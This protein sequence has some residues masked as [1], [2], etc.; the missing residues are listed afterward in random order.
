MAATFFKK[1]LV[2]PAPGSYM[3]V[4]RFYNLFNDIDCSIVSID[5]SGSVITFNIDNAVKIV[6]SSSSYSMWG[7][8]DLGT[9]IGA[10]MFNPARANFTFTICYSDTFFYFQY[11]DAYNQIFLSAYEIINGNRYFNAVNNDNDSSGITWY[12]ITKIPLKQIEN[13]TYYSHHAML[14]YT[15]PLNYIDYSSD[16]LFSG[17]TVSDYIDT[18]TLT[19]SN[20]A[21]NDILTFKGHNYYS[22]GPNT[23]IQ[24]NAN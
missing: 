13:Q 12:P 7:V 18:N 15:T 4:S 11:R 3:P 19:C 22:L 23:L 17:D 8:N 1:T 5:L 20:V 6:M 16:I 10:C 9:D 24:L 21:Q 2:N 14:S